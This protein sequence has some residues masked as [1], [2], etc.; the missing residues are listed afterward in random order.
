[1]QVNCDKG[2]GDDFYVEQLGLEQMPGG[3][4]RHWFYCPACHTHYTAYYTNP[5]IRSLQALHL[6]VSKRKR[7]TA[8]VRLLKDLK[9]RISVGMKR[10][11]SEVEG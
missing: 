5:G 2:C 6:K 4:E 7:N 8:N 10:I 1:M 3:I 11:R 9:D